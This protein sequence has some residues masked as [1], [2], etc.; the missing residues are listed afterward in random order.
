MVLLHTKSSHHGYHHIALGIFRHQLATRCRR[1][2][3]I[4]VDIDSVLDSDEMF[5]MHIG[6]QH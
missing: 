2:V 4:T 3:G 1:C 6:T 5:G